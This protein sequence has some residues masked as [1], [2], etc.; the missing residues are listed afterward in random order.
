MLTLYVLLLIFFY[1]FYNDGNTGNGLS[2]KGIGGGCQFR[3]CEVYV[4]IYNEICPVSYTYIMFLCTF[5]RTACHHTTRHV[6]KVS[7]T[8]L[9]AVKV[10]IKC[11]AKRI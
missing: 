10:N 6:A 1:V 7:H 9:S 2:G 4:T 3:K 8:S 11:D 5:Y